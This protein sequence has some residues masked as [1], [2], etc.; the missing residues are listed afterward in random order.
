MQ[1]VQLNGFTFTSFWGGEERTPKKDTPFRN[2]IAKG[3]Y[4][5]MRTYH[6]LET[7][8]VNGKKWVK[9]TYKDPD[10]PESQGVEHY[11]SECG[12]YKIQKFGKK[13]KYF[14]IYESYTW[15]KELKS[16]FGNRVTNK[17]FLTFEEA[18][19]YI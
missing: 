1:S 19:K 4:C 6:D 8:E 7:L 5:K 10:F 3:N 14:V 11:L 9:V 18:A 2:K 13:K 17:E 12:K 15:R 16:T